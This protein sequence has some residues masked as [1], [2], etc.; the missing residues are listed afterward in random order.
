MSLE[1]LSFG[2]ARLRSTK[3]VQLGS[4]WRLRLRA[5][6]L[7]P[8]LLVFLVRSC[9][10]APDGSF[11]IGGQLVADPAVLLAVGVNPDWITSELRS[12]VAVKK[13]THWDARF[14]IHAKD[15]I[16]VAELAATAL[17]TE[18]DLTSTGNILDCTLDIFGNLHA[19]NASLI[20]GTAHVLGNATVGE[21]GSADSTPTHLVL[22]RTLNKLALLGAV[23]I[24]LRARKTALN[25]KRQTLA[26]INA[27]PSGS[28]AHSDREML[29]VLMMEIPE[30]EQS[31]DRMEANRRKVARA[32]TAIDKSFLTVSTAIHPGVTLGT[33][34]SSVTFARR[35]DGPVTL[36]PTSEDTFEISG[37]PA[38]QNVS[39][40]DYLSNASKAA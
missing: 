29:T 17:S 31:I 37:G 19:P 24:Q 16:S 10:P 22:G 21:L 28:L 4:L 5:G 40:T 39:I 9:R 26:D 35:L 12:L 13:N 27:K 11:T 38:I 25:Q 20:G 34:D 30:F 32:T 3:A 15:S 23:D 36:R 7:E 18:R 6:E 1:D 8:T 2:G 33:G 14:N